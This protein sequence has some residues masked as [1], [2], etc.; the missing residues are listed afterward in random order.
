MDL[1]EEYVSN[2][3]SGTDPNQL[4]H[5][6][7]QLQME[8]QARYSQIA[9]F[10]PQISAIEDGTAFLIYSLIRI[11]RP[12]VAVETGVANGHSSF[13]ILKALIANG[14]GR[15]HSIDVAADVGALLS[16]M[17]R[18]LWQL[19]VLTGTNLKQSFTSVINSLPEIAFFLQDSD[20]T[21]RWQT[22]ELTTAWSKLE[23]DGIVVADDVDSSYAFLDFC[24]RRELKPQFLLD[25]RKAFGLLFKTEPLA[26]ADRRTSAAPVG[27]GS[28]SS[29]VAHVDP[30]R[31]TPLAVS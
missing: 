1:L 20:H 14:F 18:T 29:A 7:E 4:W 30:N 2:A 12:A 24:L 11:N 23:A 16:S 6:Y 22:Y 10:H 5:E 28:S 26:F 8:L 15:L 21:Y 27:V 31:E 17:E 3:R 13:F 9:Q 19:H 25:K